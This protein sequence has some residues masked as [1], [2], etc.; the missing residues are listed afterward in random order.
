MLVTRRLVL[1][2]YQII[3]SL[4]IYC[5]FLTL[6]EIKGDTIRVSVVYKNSENFPRFL[7]PLTETDHEKLN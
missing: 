2:L 1:Y 4:V 5:V 7:N 6:N 3:A